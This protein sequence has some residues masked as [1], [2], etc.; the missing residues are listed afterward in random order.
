MD[1][2]LFSIVASPLHPK[3][4]RIAA[5]SHIDYQVFTSERKA[6]KR[7]KK[8][9]PDVIVAD[10]VYG[11]GND[12]AGITISNLDV[13]LYSLQKEAPGAT[14]IVLAEKEEI[15]HVSKLEKIFPPFQ[16]LSYPVTEN[17]ISATLE[18]N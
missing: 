7:L 6:I 8:Q 17:D 2:V 1:M 12:Y 18:L 13:L 14:L 9:R 15:Q 5:D 3:L 4:M 11:Y 10:F 16:V